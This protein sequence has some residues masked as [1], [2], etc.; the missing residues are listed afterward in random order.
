M[1]RLKSGLQGH[2]EAPTSGRTVRLALLGSS[3]V[4]RNVGLKKN[5]TDT[6][7]GDSLGWMPF[8]ELGAGVQG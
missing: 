7:I 5:E 1:F 8:A 3:P 6:H 4:I 2:R